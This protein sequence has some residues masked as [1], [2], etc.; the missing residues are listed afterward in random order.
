[1]PRPQSRSATILPSEAFTALPN[2][3]T[4]LVFVR[5]I[6]PSACTST[7]LIPPP[8]SIWSLPALMMNVS[9][10]PAPLSWMVVPPVLTVQL[11]TRLVP[12][13]SHPP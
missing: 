4:R 2:A 13:S 1:M 10:S 6:V 12:R 11:W 7:V 5:V 9:L 8:P 3:L